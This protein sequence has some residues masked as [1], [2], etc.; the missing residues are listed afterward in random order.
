[1]ARIHDNGLAE[2]GPIQEG[3]PMERPLAF[4]AR[5]GQEHGRTI[6]LPEIERARRRLVGCK[7][8]AMLSLIRANRYTHNREQMP[9]AVDAGNATTMIGCSIP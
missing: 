4:H 1:M 6:P 8:I 7:T 3:G 9:S 2:I 5:L